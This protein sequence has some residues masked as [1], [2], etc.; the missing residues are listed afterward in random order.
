M[1][2]KDLGNLEESNFYRKGFY[3]TLWQKEMFSNNSSVVLVDW[4]IPKEL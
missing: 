3:E 1:N 4:A 2:E